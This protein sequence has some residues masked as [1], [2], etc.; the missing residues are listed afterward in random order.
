MCVCVCLDWNC[1]CS[2]VDGSP[3][4]GNVLCVAQVE[5]PATPAGTDELDS[6]V[7]AARQK[8]LRR[9]P[10]TMSITGFVRSRPEALSAEQVLGHGHS[11][12]IFWIYF[13][14]AVAMLTAITMLEDLG[15][16]GRSGHDLHDIG[17]E[18]NIGA[19]TDEG[20]SKPSLARHRSSTCSGD[21]ASVRPAMDDPYTRPPLT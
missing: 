6:L 10:H 9:V 15:R 18:A 1:I 17:A 13:V 2:V 21:R 14:V 20:P 3:C 16:C 19:R 8:H 11:G 5:G 12:R 7:Q 4:S